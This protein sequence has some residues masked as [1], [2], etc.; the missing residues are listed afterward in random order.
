[1][2]SSINLDKLPLHYQMKFQH[3]RLNLCGE[4]AENFALSAYYMALLQLAEADKGRLP[5]VCDSAMARVQAAADTDR[6]LADEIAGYEY[7]LIQ[8]L[9]QERVHG[10]AYRWSSKRGYR[11]AAEWMDL[12]KEDI[13]AQ[14]LLIQEAVRLCRAFRRNLI[15]KRS[16]EGKNKTVKLEVI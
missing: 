1:M 6:A 2:N 14:D 7:A 12:V 15:V 13:A 11:R 8:F 10:L 16:Q 4:N 9:D 3:F 5:R